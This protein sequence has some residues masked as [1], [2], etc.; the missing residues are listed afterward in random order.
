MSTNLWQDWGGVITLPKTDIV[1]ELLCLED[2]R[3]LLGCHLFRGHVSSLE[4]IFLCRVGWLYVM[5]TPVQR[6]PRYDDTRIRPWNKHNV[7]QRK[8][9]K[10]G[11][12]TVMVVG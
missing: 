8:D 7:R 2:D 10:S 12:L 6:C 3:F 11:G 5:R 1:P 4:C 9:G